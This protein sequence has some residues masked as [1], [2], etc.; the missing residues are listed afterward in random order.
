M[1]V[2]EKTILSDVIRQDN[3]QTR[4]VIHKEKSYEYS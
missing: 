4:K 3:H 2:K 1:S